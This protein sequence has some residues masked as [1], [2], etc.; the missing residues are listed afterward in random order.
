[1]S[2]DD[3]FMLGLSLGGGGG[4]SGGGDEDW[5][6]PEHWL[7]IPDP[8][9][10]QVIIYVEAESAGYG[11]VVQFHSNSDTDY[12]RSGVVEW[13]DG[14]SSAVVSTAELSAS[15]FRICHKYTDAGQYIVKINCNNHIFNIA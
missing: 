4:G 8:E 10:N 6:F 11:F 7:D 13:G 15:N 2:F 14:T 9:P 5:T 3:G 12:T 1:M